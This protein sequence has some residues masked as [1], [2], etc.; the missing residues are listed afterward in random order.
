MNEQ[1]RVFPVSLDW[2]RRASRP[3]FKL[4]VQRRLIRECIACLACRVFHLFYEAQKHPNRTMPVPSLSALVLLLAVGTIATASAQQQKPQ[5]DAILTKGIES[6]LF[7]GAVAI[8]GRA[9]DILYTGNVG[10]FT[11]DSS[12]PAMNVADT[13]FDMASCSK[14]IG[15]TS[16][17]ALPSSCREPLEK[18]PRASREVAGSLLRSSL[19]PLIRSSLKLLDKLL[20]A[21][22][23]SQQ[24]I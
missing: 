21:S 8:V 12:S 5:L 17:V 2:R 6:G 7:P 10:R 13:I 15:T 1:C 18:L 19:K 3:E 24:L 22:R 23:G 14:V 11:N 9:K 20:G 4:L 16:A